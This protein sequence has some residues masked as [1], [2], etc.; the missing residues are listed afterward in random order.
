MSLHG[1]LQQVLL[2]GLWGR[3]T[4]QLSFFPMLWISTYVVWDKA[5]SRNDTPLIMSEGLKG[6]VSF[7][8]FCLK[9]CSWHLNKTEIGCWRMRDLREESSCCRWD[10]LNQHR[11]SWFRMALSMPVMRKC[12]SKWWEILPWPTVDNKMNEH[13]CKEHSS[14][15]VH[16]FVSTN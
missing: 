2:S 6:L 14:I 1:V 7:C 8:C 5:G 13:T 15:P 10:A 12:W 11:A 9:T 3:V 16:R 4:W